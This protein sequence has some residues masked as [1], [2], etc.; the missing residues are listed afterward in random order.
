MVLEVF[1]GKL[2]FIVNSRMRAKI[3]TIRRNT[4]IKPYLKKLLQHKSVSG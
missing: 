2:T 4:I 3:K 1:V